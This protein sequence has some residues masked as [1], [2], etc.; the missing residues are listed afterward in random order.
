MSLNEFIARATSFFDK[1]EAQ[2]VDQAAVAAVRKELD[3]AKSTIA[4]RDAS[5]ETLK[6]S[7]EKITNDATATAAELTKLKAEMEAEKTRTDTTLA[8]AGVDPKTIPAE[9]PA[10][11]GGSVIEKLSAIED[12]RERAVFFQQHKAEI[13][14]ARINLK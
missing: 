7:L 14:K 12:P 5:I 10:A 4:T 6:A 8:A 3:D 2:T 11:T 1:A 13:L 9:T